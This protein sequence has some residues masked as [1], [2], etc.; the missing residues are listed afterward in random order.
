MEW[1]DAIKS[2]VDTNATSVVVVLYFLLLMTWIYTR[3]YVYPFVFLYNTFFIAFD[4][5]MSIFFHRAMNVM[6]SMLQVLHVY[7]FVLFLQMGY[8]LVRKGIQEDIQQKCT[9][10]LQEKEQ[11]QQ[12]QQQDETTITTLKKQKQLTTTTRRTRVIL[13]ATTIN[14]AQAA[15]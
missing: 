13:P 5:Q 12:Q 11:Q 15:T 9:Q 14:V 2:V 6:L 4:D 10:Q 3:L 1:L 7:W 8:Q